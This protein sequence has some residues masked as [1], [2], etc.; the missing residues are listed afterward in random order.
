M[1]TDTTEY[2]K[3]NTDLGD[4]IRYMAFKVTMCRIINKYALLQLYLSLSSPLD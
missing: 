2:N 1:K 4:N 3:V